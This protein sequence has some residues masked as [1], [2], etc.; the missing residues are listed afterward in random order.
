MTY[1]GLLML[2][3]GIGVSRLLFG[4]K[5]RLW[6]AL[7]MPA[8]AVTLALTLSR[9]AWIGACAATAMLLALRDFRLLAVIPVVAAIAFVAAPSIVSQRF[10]SMFDPTDASR[11][12]R[13]AMLRE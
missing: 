11:R 12:D 1:S 4:T 13:A 8:L 5:G 3:L 6:A 7:V 9:S 2:V 10:A